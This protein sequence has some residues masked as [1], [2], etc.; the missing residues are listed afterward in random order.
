MNFGQRPVL[1][2]RSRE[3]LAEL[4]ANVPLKR[5]KPAPDLHPGEDQDKTSVDETS[6]DFK[7]ALE[8]NVANEVFDIVD[9]EEEEVAEDSTK[10]AEQERQLAEWFRHCER[11]DKLSSLDPEERRRRIETCH[12]RYAFMLGSITEKALSTNRADVFNRETRDEVPFTF[13][14]WTFLV[15][16]SVEKAMV[17][18]MA[19]LPDAVKVILGGPLTTKEL[20]MLPEKW[21]GLNLWAIYGDFL[22]GQEETGRYCG[23]GT[24]ALEGVVARLRDYENIVTKGKKVDGLRHGQ[25]L[26]RARKSEVKMNLRILAVFNQC[27]TQKPY[28]LLMELLTTI[29]LQTLP[30]SSGSGPYRSTSVVEM[31]RDATPRDLPDVEHTSLNGAAQCRQGLCGKQTSL[32]K[33][34]AVCGTT[35]MREGNHWHSANPGL[36]FTGLICGPCEHYRRDH[37]GNERPVEHEMRRRHL[38]QLESA[39]GPKPAAGTACPG[40]RCVPAVGKWLFPKGNHASEPERERWECSNC[41]PK[42]TN[43]LGRPKKGGTAAKGSAR[44]NLLSQ[45]GDKPAAGTPCPGCDRPPSKQWLLPKGDLAL[46]PGRLRWECSTC[47]SKPTSKLQDRRKQKPRT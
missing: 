34:C 36:P 47:Y 33:V 24:N 41:A 15:T 37:D 29:L 3:P 13:A 1:G 10:A 22:V 21:K 27:R 23:S 46:E 31:V 8:D 18:L 25:W 39:I 2:K 42:A 17:P 38:I 43:M 19:S 4:P 16:I 6:S 35:E 28:V 26:L 5:S 40:C 20:L 9:D 12:E 32:A 44:A 14:W 11:T 45:A 30:D 7:Q